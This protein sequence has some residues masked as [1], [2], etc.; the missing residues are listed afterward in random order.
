MALGFLLFGL[1]TAIVG[2]QIDPCAGGY[3][4]LYNLLSSSIFGRG[5]VGLLSLIVG[6]KGL[7]IAITGEE[8]LIE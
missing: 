5:I 1:V 2:Y 6:W 8:E 3:C 7:T 4:R